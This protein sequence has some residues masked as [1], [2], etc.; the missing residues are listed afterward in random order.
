MASTKVAGV[1]VAAGIAEILDS[2]E[3]AELIAR[4]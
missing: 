2:P 4:T 1:P 3:V